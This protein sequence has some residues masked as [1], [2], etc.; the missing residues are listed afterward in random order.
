[1]INLTVE[2]PV[3]LL[4]SLT[5]M[6]HQ[7]QDFPQEMAQ[8]M[9]DWQSDDMKRAYP[10]TVVYHKTVSTVIWP[11]GESE[12][13]RS[14]MLQRRVKKQ[15][16]NFLSFRRRKV[17]IKQHVIRLKKTIYSQNAKSRPILREVLWDKLVNRMTNLLDTIAWQ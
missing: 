9:T 11:R 2:N 14:M 16:S 6:L 5:D 12:A 13:Q 4:K 3:D 1:M 15:V 7:L 17:R 10:Y 8:E